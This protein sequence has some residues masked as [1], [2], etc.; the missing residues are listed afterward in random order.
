MRSDDDKKNYWRKYSKFGQHE[1]VTKN[2]TLNQNNQKEII[3]M[4]TSL[5]GQLFSGG[6]K[7]LHRTSC[8]SS[9]TKILDD[10]MMRSGWRV[11][12]TGNGKRETGKW[13]MGTKQR[14]GNENTD[15]AAVPSSFPRF[16]PTSP[17][18]LS[19]G[20][21]EN[22]AT[23]L[24]GFK[25]GFVPVFHF[26]IPRF[27]NISKKSYLDNQEAGQWKWTTFS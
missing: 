3:T 24:F 7:K 27:S 15:R 17:Y 25:L 4:K 6:D 20:R 5:I 14:I 9:N 23:R 8:L 26:P 16:S 18:G 22:L 12:G 1:Q 21:R 10:T 13:K 19:T 11:Q 2:W